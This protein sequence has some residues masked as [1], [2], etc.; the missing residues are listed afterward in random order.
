MSLTL[1]R[2]C[3]DRPTNKRRPR[4]TS[5]GFHALRCGFPRERSERP[6]ALRYGLNC[7]LQQG[8]DAARVRCLRRSSISRAVELSCADHGIAGLGARDESYSVVLGL[9]AHGAAERVAAVLQARRVLARQQGQD[10]EYVRRPSLSSSP[11]TSTACDSMHFPKAGVIHQR[12]FRAMDKM[13]PGGRRP[14]STSTFDFALRSERA[15]EAAAVARRFSRRFH[16]GEFRGASSSTAR[17][18]E[19]GVSAH[20]TRARRR[21]RDRRW[22]GLRRV[23]VL[24]AAV[25]ASRN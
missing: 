6:F 12:L 5:P 11:S 13:R 21:A 24:A 15:Q 9:A 25:A 3:F 14:R 4:C 8:V 7:F 19:D 18:L 2:F 22:W 17:R 16:V 23:A 10:D 1:P 20:L